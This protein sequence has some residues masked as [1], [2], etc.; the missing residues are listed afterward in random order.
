M[1]QFPVSDAQGIIDGLNYVLSGPTGV[2]QNTAGFN[3]FNSAELTGNFRPPFTASSAKFWIPAIALGTATWIDSRTWRFD[4]AAPE[5]T[6]PF[7][8]GNGVYVTGVTPAD[9]NGGY[10]VIGVVECTTTYVIVRSVE[11]YAN[12]GA[13]TGGTIEF[14]NDTFSSAENPISTDCN[15]KVT[16]NGIQETVAINAQLNNTITYSATAPVTF[17]Y[18][19]QIA[20]YK[21]SPNNDPTN[22]DFFFSERQLVSEQT[23][24]YYLDATE[25][26]LIDFNAPAGVKI[27]YAQPADGAF[28][29]A[30]KFI[31]TGV[32]ATT[33][34][35]NDAVLQIEVSYG[36]AGAYTAAN[37]RV[38][39]IAPGSNWTNGSTIVIDGTN[40][41]GVSGVND[42]TLT[43]N[44]VEN[45]TK[46]LDPIETIFTG[47]SD[48]PVPG[49]YWYI[50]EVN[51]YSIASTGPI[52][53]HTSEL[54]YRSFTAQVVKP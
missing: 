1:A 32:N 42:L 30:V 22:P 33:G 46:T 13:G 9:Y 49:Y 41:G 10:Y 51:F 6:P 54:G 19:V 17:E 11:E 53:I 39:V 36:G 20:R 3:D 43:V 25:G 50:M 16:V 28:D 47:I 8:P 26:A 27:A 7:Q 5:P 38:T 34:T 37:T 52:Y 48:N 44:T 23:Y 21:G 24:Y 14:Y 31:L 45:G 29:P 40:F 2:G 35:G 18:K 15:G 12:P 4:F